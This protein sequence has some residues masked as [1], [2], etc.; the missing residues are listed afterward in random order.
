MAYAFVLLTGLFFT[1]LL[2]PFALIGLPV[3]IVTAWLS[4]AL[5]RIECARLSLLLGVRIRPQPMPAGDRNPPRYGG[6]LWRDPG[7]RRRGAHQLLALP[8]GV[9]TSGITYFLLSGAV[10]LLAMAVLTFLVPSQGTTVFGIPFA[11]TV[12]GRAPLA[13]IG[14][15]LLLPPWCAASP[16]STCRPLVPCWDPRARRTRTARRRAGVQPRTGRRRRGGRA[17]APRA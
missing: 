16:R 17:Q 2:L 5:A 3:W 11:D 4:V 6:I 12:G 14:L 10:A 15:V 7:V 9:L 1:V 13:G 8:L